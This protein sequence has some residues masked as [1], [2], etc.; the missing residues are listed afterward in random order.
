M[1]LKFFYGFTVLADILRWVTLFLGRLVLSGEDCLLKY[2]YDRYLV[3]DR[4]IGVAWG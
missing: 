3:V 2:G 4:R 1:N